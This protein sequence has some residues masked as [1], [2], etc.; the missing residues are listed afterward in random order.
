VNDIAYDRL[1]DL[2]S[3]MK[4]RLK[5]LF[6]SQPF[7][8]PLDTGGKIRTAKLLEQLTKIFDIT[9]ISNF[10]PS[11]DKLY[12]DSM[13]A[14]CRE[15][16]PVR[17]NP[18]K[19][20]SPLFYLR[21][22]TRIF[23]RY[24]IVVLN[25]Y[26]KEI[27]ETILRLL[28]KERYD[29]LI[30]DFLQPS[31]NFCKVVGFP[32]LLFQHNVE[33]VIARRHFEVAANPFLKVFWWSQWRKMQRYEREMCQRFTGTVTVSEIDKSLLEEKFGARNVFSIPTGVDTY[34]FSPSEKTEVNNSLVFTGSM[35]WL[36]NEDAVLFF[37]KQIFGKIKAKIPSVTVTVVGRNPSKRLLAAL[38]TYPEIKCTGWVSD[39]R[40]YL[41][42][43]AVYIVPLRIG[44]GTRIKIYEAM[45]MGKAIV[46]TSVGSEGLPLTD[47]QN[48]V[49]ADTP[50]RFSDGVIELLGNPEKRMKMEVA[51]RQFVRQNCS[52]EGVAKRFA[53]VSLTVART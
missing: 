17:W 29:L 24:P 18:I 41:G 30:C 43:H 45:A 52:W 5:V 48:V 34:Y 32:I 37:A 39:I 38:K 49:I 25:D 53:E 12:F 40:P 47:G 36:P 6:L 8:Y 2:Q 26:S 35:D 20:Y 19:K 22:L 51:A 14:L 42:C 50:E 28:S 33:S 3:S 16:H 1:C 4:P 15:Y 21:L 27:E 10:D 13:T 31:L 9:L 11:K 44:G 46:C 23:S 7:L